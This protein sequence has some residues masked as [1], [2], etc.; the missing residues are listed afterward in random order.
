MGSETSIN[1]A[2]AAFF[3]LYCA[4]K[5]GARPLKL[6]AKQVFTGLLA[7]AVTLGVLLVGQRVYQTMV[8]QSPLTTNLGTIQGVRQASFHHSTVTVRVSPHANL[9]GVYQAVMRR[10]IASLGHAPQKVIIIG[11][12]DP[13]LT[14]LA[15]N[16]SFVV[17]QGEATGQFVAMKHTITTMAQKIG[18]S[19]SLQL[20]D[21][22]LY[23]TFTARHHVLYDVIPIMIGGGSHG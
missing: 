14:H 13:A 16:I 5:K 8:V 3:M 18:A 12:P 19:C 10:A 22:R 20:D 2:V 7:L 4:P 9:M 17:A 11:H 23:A 6:S 21:H 1:A 15:N